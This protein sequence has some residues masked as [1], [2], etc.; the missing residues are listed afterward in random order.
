[1]GEMERDHHV[2]PN[3]PSR[4][5]PATWPQPPRAPSQAEGFG[6]VQL[7]CWSG[8]AQQAPRG[9]DPIPTPSWL[10]VRETDHPSS[11]CLRRRSERSE[12]RHEMS[13]GTEGSEGTDGGLYSRRNT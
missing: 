8:L 9:H 12:S 4:G 2:P 6:T 3:S 1:M 7:L 5:S 13:W 10:A 11:N